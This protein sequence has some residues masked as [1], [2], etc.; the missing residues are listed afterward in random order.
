MHLGYQFGN[1]ERFRNNVVLSYML[2][3]GTHC[4][5]L[6]NGLAYHSCFLCHGDLFV[7]RVRCNLL[8]VSVDASINRRDS[9]YCYDRHWPC[10]FALLLPLS[11]FSYASQTVHYCAE[12]SMCMSR[13]SGFG[14]PGISRSM[15]MID[16][17]VAYGPQS[18]ANDVFSKNK[19]AS[20]P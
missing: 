19:R 8:H 15:R 7:T 9:T 5:S 18:F 13:R 20:A 4:Y 12:F 6:Q 11:D 14:S 17:G 1:L 2:V 3:H 10:K 16:S